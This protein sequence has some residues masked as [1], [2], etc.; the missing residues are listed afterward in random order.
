MLTLKL[1]HDKNGPHRMSTVLFIC[2]RALSLQAYT[3][4][5]SKDMHSLFIKE[6]D[7]P[8]LPRADPHQQ[9]RIAYKAA[10][11]ALKQLSIPAY[12]AIKARH[13]HNEDRRAELLEDQGGKDGI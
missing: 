13:D 8:F 7:L 5:Y 6:G 10:M 11:K 2:A 12:N 4:S 3:V 1:S 9:L